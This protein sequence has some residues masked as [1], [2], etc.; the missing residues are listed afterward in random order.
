MKPLNELLYHRLV[1]TFGNVQVVND[2]A[3]DQTPLP[4]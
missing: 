3:P 2:G 1:K 4:P